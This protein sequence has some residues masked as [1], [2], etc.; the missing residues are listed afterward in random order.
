MGRIDR[1]PPPAPRRPR[2]WMVVLIWLVVLLLLLYAALPYLAIAVAQH[3][4][5][6]P[7]GDGATVT[8]ASAVA[9]AHPIEVAMYVQPG[10]ARRLLRE[11]EG[12]W[13]P[14]W[15]LRS[16][17]S[18]GGTVGIASAPTSVPTMLGWR[19]VISSG[20]AP[21]TLLLRLTAA[22]VAAMLAP[23]ASI[24]LDPARGIAISY[25]V[26]RSDLR[27]EDRR[28]GDAPEWNLRIEAQG[29]L[30]MSIGGMASDV[31]VSRLLAH[32]RIRFTRVAHGWS[33]SAVVAIDSIESPSTDLP[34]VTSPAT[35]RQLE[36]LL[37]GLLR[38][39]AAGV[40]LPEWFPMDAVV[41]GRVGAEVL[42]E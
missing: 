20:D 35:R 11:G 30:G 40:T 5:P 17:Q 13:L 2:R 4:L 34:M 9:P 10:R 6:H 7:A 33:P 31:P 26:E 24:D 22:E 15:L 41:E 28:A 32:L 37:N 8:E 23:Y 1:L 39:Q 29:R 12:V 36:G 25:V 42:K 21:P 27:I 16:G 3:W 38:R 18:V 14:P 19:L